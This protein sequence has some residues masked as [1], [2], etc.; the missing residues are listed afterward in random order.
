MSTLIITLPLP[1]ASEGAGAAALEVA[2]AISEGGS[3]L[4]QH[5]NA[6]LALLPRPVRSYTEVVAVV[7][8]QALSWQQVVLPKGSLGSGS[9]RLRAVLD[10]L[11]EERLLDDVDKLH[12]ALQPGAISDVPVWVAV[13][14]KS[15][16]QAG[17]QRLEAAQLPVTRIV[18][19]LAPLLPGANASALDTPTSQTLHVLGE[20]GQPLLVACDAS[21]VSLLPLT[22]SAL[23][24]ALGQPPGAPVPPDAAGVLLLAEPAM[25][26]QA[27]SLLQH[28][29]SLQQSSTRSLLAAQSLWDLGQFALVNSSRTRTFKSLADVGRALWRAPQWRM[30]RYGLALLA[31]VQLV[32]LNAFAWREAAALEAQRGAV[33]EVLTQSFPNVKVVL[34][35]PLQMAREVARLQQAAGSA[36]A[37]DLEAML[38]ALSVA[39]PPG[40]TLNAIEYVAGTARVKG[41]RLGADETARL[42]R[43]GYAASTEGEALVIKPAVPGSAP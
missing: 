31:L 26:A 34:D 12:F 1:P 27:E 5:G 23:A 21:G 39:A 7:P 9:P 15:W 4:V 35:A 17:L 11:L 13:C 8:V 40:Q 16:L 33:R 43:Q 6:P 24:L 14:D 18:P 37:R 41:V 25:A 19:E 28:K 29:V 32:G 36:T 10:G 2:Y 38:S 42:V 22:A 30:A 3:N 20:P